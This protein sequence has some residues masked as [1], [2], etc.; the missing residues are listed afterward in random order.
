MY[1]PK[2]S[3]L[4]PR[5]HSKYGNKKVI[6]DGI[7]FDSKHEADIYLKLKTAE[8]CGAI[9][10]LRLQVPFELQEKYTIN[11]RTVRAVK[12]VADFV[13]VN[14]AGEQ[15]VWDAKGV[16]TDVYKLKKKLFEYKYRTEIK[17]V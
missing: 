1:L 13:F 10:K 3:Y 15:E 17:E 8:K 14:K 2:Y 12:Y 11:G 6:A 5:K 16:K 9:S 4:Q 7:K